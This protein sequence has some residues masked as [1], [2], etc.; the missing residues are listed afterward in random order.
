MSS[1][2][3]TRTR[4]PS[5][6]R[7]YNE[8]HFETLLLDD[9]KSTQGGASPGK[10]ETSR[11]GGGGTSRVEEERSAIKARSLRATERAREADLEEQ[12]KRRF[13]RHRDEAKR[14]QAESER[15]VRRGDRKFR[16]GVWRA[17]RVGRGV[18]GR[19]DW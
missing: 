19:E 6:V 11:S 12:R 5:R 3:R 18:Q 8:D 16:W 4:E 15:Q 17:W 9:D 7:I 1:T 2:A 14:M 13:E 10:P